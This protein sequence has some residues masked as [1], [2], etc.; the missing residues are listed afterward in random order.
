MQGH[1][2]C[3][4]PRCLDTS[5]EIDQNTQQLSV[6]QKSHNRNGSNRKSECN[7]VAVVLSA[8]ARR[9]KGSSIAGSWGRSFSHLSKKP[10][11]CARLTHQSTEMAIIYIY[12]F[13][14]F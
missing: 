14:F 6:K 4:Y 2:L 1:G 8:Q 11:T 10:Y 9:G 3:L 12:T 5:G 7:T 13:F